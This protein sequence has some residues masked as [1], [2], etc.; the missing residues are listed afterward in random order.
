MTAFCSRPMAFEQDFLGILM[1]V[2]QW[3]YLEYIYIVNCHLLPAHSSNLI[4]MAN[5][6]QKRTGLNGIR[7][8]T[9][10]VTYLFLL[11]VAEVLGGGDMFAIVV[12]ELNPL[13]IRLEICRQRQTKH[14][15]FIWRTQTSSME[16]RRR[17]IYVDQSEQRK[18]LKWVLLI[19]GQS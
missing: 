2:F 14:N 9:K 16:G 7:Q 19:H 1:M 6:G 8:K 11:L 5:F 15:C 13:Y 17:R 18:N 12:H 4:P 10:M 3:E